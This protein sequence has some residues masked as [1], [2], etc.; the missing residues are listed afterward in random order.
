MFTV[1]RCHRKWENEKMFGKNFQAI[2]QAGMAPVEFQY[3]H[4]N[5]L[6]SKYNN[7][8]TTSIATT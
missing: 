2:I 1:L 3:F 6:V 7:P 5:K 4:G 8:A